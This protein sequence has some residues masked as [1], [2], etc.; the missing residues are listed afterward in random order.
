M[1]VRDSPSPTVGQKYTGADCP[2]YKVFVNKDY[3]RYIDRLMDRLINRLI[4]RI[5]D[6]FIGR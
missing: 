5:M 2:V 6:W 1:I 4:E 3:D